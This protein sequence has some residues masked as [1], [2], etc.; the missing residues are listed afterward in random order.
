MY[1]LFFKAEVVTTYILGRKEYIIILYMDQSVNT[2]FLLRFQRNTFLPFV[3]FTGITLDT[4]PYQEVIFLLSKPILNA[5]LGLVRLRLD[6]RELRRLNFLLFNWIEG[7]LIPLTPSIQTQ[8]NKALNGTIHR[9]FAI[10]SP[11]LL[12]ILYRLRYI[13]LKGL[14]SNQV[15]S[16]KLI[17][18]RFVFWIFHRPKNHSRPW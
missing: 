7:N 12:T 15:S 4:R 8:S 17:S 11:F 16:Q 9:I 10:V 18:C 14:S 6:W 3:R 5:T 1:F 2:S 13:Y